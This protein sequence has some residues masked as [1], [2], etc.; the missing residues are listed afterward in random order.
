MYHYLYK[1]IDFVPAGAQEYSKRLLE[2]QRKQVVK[3]VR[4]TSA[5]A[6]NDMQVLAVRV[7]A[8]P[9]PTSP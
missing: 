9:V 5:T 7:A 1:F 4:F 6:A 2:A 3:E 8:P